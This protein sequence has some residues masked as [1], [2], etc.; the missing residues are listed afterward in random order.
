MWVSASER[1]VA[2]VVWRSLVLIDWLS[3]QIG[4]FGVNKGQLFPTPDPP[5]SYFLLLLTNWPTDQKVTDQWSGVLVLIALNVKISFKAKY[6]PPLGRKQWSSCW[7]MGGQR[8]YLSYNTGLLDDASR[9]KPKTDPTLL[10]TTPSHRMMYQEDYL[11]ITYYFVWNACVCALP[12][13]STTAQFLVKA[14]LM[15]NSGLE[16]DPSRVNLAEE[17]KLILQQI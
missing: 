13:F 3:R 16:L 11:H 8:Y 9:W 10:L 5:A 14:K 7:L 2:A 15:K 6:C 1:A 17:E 12:S 4:L